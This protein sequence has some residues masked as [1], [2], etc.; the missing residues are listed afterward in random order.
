MATEG[1]RHC[2]RVDAPTAHAV[3]QNLKKK[4]K[5][6]KKVYFRAFMISNMVAGEIL[7]R[8]RS[9]K[10][11]KPFKILPTLPRFEEILM[12]TKPEEWSPNATFEATRI[13]VSAKPAVA[14][15]FFEMVLLEKVREDIYEN[16]VLNVHY[17]K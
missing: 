4:K 8:Y 14:Q 1:S 6:K 7:K 2:T 9:G 3:K 17:F 16:K 11:P 15:R 5:K 13:F 12:I 10:L